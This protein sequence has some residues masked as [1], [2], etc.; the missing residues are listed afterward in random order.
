MTNSKIKSYSSDYPYF[1]NQNPKSNLTKP[2]LVR[3]TTTSFHNL[4][5]STYQLLDLR[6]IKLSITLFLIINHTMTVDFDDQVSS[7]FG[8]LDQFTLTFRIN[9]AEISF[10]PVGIFQ[11]SSPSTVLNAVA[12]CDLFVA[13][14][15]QLFRFRL[16]LY[17]LLFYYFT[18]IYLDTI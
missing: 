13:V 11:V 14:Y 9:L 12:E 15:I 7:D 17:L 8:I 10:N 4:L 5:Q 2:I 18:S 3:T 6:V 1:N 16:H